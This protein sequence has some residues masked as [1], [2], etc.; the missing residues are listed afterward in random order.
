MQIIY[1]RNLMSVDLNKML[2]AFRAF[3]LFKTLFGFA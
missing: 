2:T 3:R 1:F